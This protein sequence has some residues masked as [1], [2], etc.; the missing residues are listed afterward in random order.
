MC[1]MAYK[2]KQY[3]FNTFHFLS[4]FML[5][6]SQKEMIR[7]GDQNGVIYSHILYFAEFQRLGEI[8]EP[9]FPSLSKDLA[10]CVRESWE[11]SRLSLK[12]VHV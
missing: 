11:S 4:I 10:S 2:K 9:L 1:D 8:K 5:E 6:L 7:S 12:V 3:L